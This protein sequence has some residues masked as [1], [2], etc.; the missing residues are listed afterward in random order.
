MTRPGNNNN[1]KKTVRSRAEESLPITCCSLF[2]KNSWSLLPELRSLAALY[3]CEIPGDRQPTVGSRG[4]RTALD[5]Q[6]TGSCH[7]AWPL[8]HR[9][10]HCFTTNTAMHAFT[11]PLPLLL[12]SP[13]PKTTARQRPH[14]TVS[15]TLSTPPL[16]QL[17]L[18][19][20]YPDSKAFNGESLI[21]IENSKKNGVNSSVQ[22]SQSEWLIWGELRPATRA[23]TQHIVINAPKLALHFTA[24]FLGDA[25]PSMSFVK[26]LISG[27][28]TYM[29]S[30]LALSLKEILH[31]MAKQ[32]EEED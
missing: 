28:P 27:V 21:S 17:L 10:H 32:G 13:S 14:A 19:L 6:G 23:R 3:T 29:E 2:A 11:L 26:N 8:T 18:L 25:V 9:P 31:V 7:C 15:E 4:K 5:F 30:L 16:S 22:F 24:F 20:G 12:S 1:K